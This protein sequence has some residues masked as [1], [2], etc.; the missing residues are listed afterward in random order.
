MNGAGRETPQR[1]LDPGSI[2]VVDE[3]VRFAEDS[4]LRLTLPFTHQPRLWQEGDP[5]RFSPKRRGDPW[6]ESMKR[7]DQ[8]DDEMCRAWKEDIDTLLVFVSNTRFVSSSLF[9]SL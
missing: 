3:V 4:G 2:S 8:Y 9:L 6:E 7:V 1:E 5:Y